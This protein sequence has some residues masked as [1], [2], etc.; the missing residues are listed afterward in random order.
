MET[1]YRELAAGVPPAS[2]LR[3]AKLALAR[4]E[5]RSPLYWAPFVLVARAP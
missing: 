5:H 2:A 3:N 1:F 4:G